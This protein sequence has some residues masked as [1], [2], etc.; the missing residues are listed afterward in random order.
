MKI[1]NPTVYLP[2]GLSLRLL[3]GLSS[4]TSSIGDEKVNFP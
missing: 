1:Y 2:N 3:T 4:S